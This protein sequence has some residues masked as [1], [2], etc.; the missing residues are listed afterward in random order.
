VLLEPFRAAGRF[1]HSEVEL[2]PPELE[3]SD[4]TLNGE[5]EV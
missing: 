4:V 2:S 1:Y 3:R 5:Q